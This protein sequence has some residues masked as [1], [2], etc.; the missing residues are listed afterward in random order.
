MPRTLQDIPQTRRTP[1]MSRKDKTSLMLIG[2]F[3][4]LLT[5]A[6][7]GAAAHYATFIR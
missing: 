1:S 3:V 4:L 5:V 2:L 6:F 7:I